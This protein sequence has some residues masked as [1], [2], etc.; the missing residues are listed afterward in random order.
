M[1]ALSVATILMVYSTE[2]ALATSKKRNAP[3]AKLDKV[4]RDFV[5]REKISASIV[6]SGEIYV[7]RSYMAQFKAIQGDGAAIFS[8]PNLDSKM[9]M[10]LNNGAKLTADAEYTNKYGGDWYYVHFGKRAKG[11]VAAVYITDREPDENE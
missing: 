5:K 2:P 11:W 8:E 6:S 1:L 7:I 10:K 4:T 9:I 3:I